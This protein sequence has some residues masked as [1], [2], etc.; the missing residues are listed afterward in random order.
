MYNTA[1]TGDASSQWITDNKH[2]V[3]SNG[4]RLDGYTPE[5]RTIRISSYDGGYPFPVDEAKALRRA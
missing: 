5:S 3:I 4:Y 2:A 1:Q